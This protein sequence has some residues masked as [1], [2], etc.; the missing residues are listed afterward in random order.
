VVTNI[1]LLYVMLQ[2]C[3]PHNLVKL[4]DPANVT[5]PTKEVPT[6]QNLLTIKSTNR[7]L[8]LVQFPRN[9]GTST[10]AREG[11]LSPPPVH[12]LAHTHTGR[13][14]THTHAQ[15]LTCTLTGTHGPRHQSQEKTFQKRR[16]RQGGVTHFCCILH[17]FF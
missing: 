16:K 8:S 15:K 17:S 13:G 14:H 11:S 12:I 2:P 6:P 10:S 9:G 7:R 1:M 4:T 5:N 3:K